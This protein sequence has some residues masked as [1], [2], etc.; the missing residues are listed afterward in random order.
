VDLLN[1]ANQMEKKKEGS[2][3]RKYDSEFKEE[4]LK[5]IS[6]GRPVREVSESLGVGENLIYRWKSLNS[7]KAGL[8]G[9]SAVPVISTSVP[10]SEHEAIRVRL[11]EVE[12]ER[13]IL[14][15]A[16]GIFSR[17]N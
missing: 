1:L 15:K 17:G 13:D 14:K 4:V 16:L 6:N 12:Q 2:G 9:A 5:M 10:A 3:R 11:R 7:G 8:S